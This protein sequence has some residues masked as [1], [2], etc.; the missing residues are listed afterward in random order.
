MSLPALLR[1]IKYCTVHCQMI[2]QAVIGDSPLRAVA[3]RAMLHQA[4][5]YWWQRVHSP[6]RGCLSARGVPTRLQSSEGC[7]TKLLV[8]YREHYVDKKKKKLA[9]L[10]L[11]PA[12]RDV[13]FPLLWITL[14]PEKELWKMGGSSS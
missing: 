2:G 5:V 4:V 11:E 12:E 9:R 8:R 10:G 1:A 7:D 6:A 14:R 13:P 3:A